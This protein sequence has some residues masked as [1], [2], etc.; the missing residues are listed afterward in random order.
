ML[1]DL[2]L[3]VVVRGIK[4]KISRG[5]QLEEILETYSLLNEDT[6]QQIR[7]AVNNI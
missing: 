3:G 1:S 4:V 7:E 5:Q 6:K 2:A